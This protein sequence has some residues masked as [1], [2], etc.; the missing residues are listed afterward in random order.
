MSDP[1]KMIAA[2]CR[3][4]DLSLTLHMNF[5]NYLWDA[6]ATGTGVGEFWEVKILATAE[7]ACIWLLKKLPPAHTRESRDD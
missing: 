3:A 6:D 5:A 4:L 7:D 2:R 1:I